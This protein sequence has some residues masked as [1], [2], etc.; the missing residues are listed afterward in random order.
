MAK[1]PKLGTGK[2]FASL[3]STLAKRGATNPGALAAAIGRKK[4][5]AKK[6]ASL[7]AHGRKR[8]GKPGLGSTAV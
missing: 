2:R 5:G 4:Y 6:M 8:K 1:K 3:S 7:S